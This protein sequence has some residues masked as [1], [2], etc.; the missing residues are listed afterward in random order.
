MGLQKHLYEDSSS[1]EITLDNAFVGY[2]LGKERKINLCQLKNK[3]ELDELKL[4]N[5]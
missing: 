4:L 1:N 3:S 2:V 5:I